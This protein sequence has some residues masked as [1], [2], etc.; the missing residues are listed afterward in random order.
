MALYTKGNWTVDEM[1]TPAS[2]TAITPSV[3]T[4]T[5]AEYSAKKSGN[6]EAVLVNNTGNGL[7]TPEAVRFGATP[8][9]NVYN[10]SE[11]PA[12]MQFPMKNGI[13]L[14]QEIRTNLQATNSVSGETRVVP[15]RAWVVCETIQNEVVTSAAIEYLMKRLIGLMIM[16][17]DGHTFADRIL[18]MARGD[19]D[20]ST[21]V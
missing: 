7:I 6:G 15:L 20:P 13:R 18:S 9:A 3:A 1:I 4:L 8:V 2:S 5:R 16:G 12:G 21:A 19:L 11:V 14:L 10:G 17:V